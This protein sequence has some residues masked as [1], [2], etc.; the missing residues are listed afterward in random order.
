MSEF[1]D[2]SD[3]KWSMFSSSGL[4]EVVVQPEVDV[5]GVV[6]FPCLANTDSP[7]HLN[8]D[9]PP[10][11]LDIAPGVRERERVILSPIT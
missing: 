7:P 8:E 2:Q 3:T 1:G 11:S 5:G 6:E 10:H 9:P 4:C